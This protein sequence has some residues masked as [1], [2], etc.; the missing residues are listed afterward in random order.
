MHSQSDTVGDHYREAPRQQSRDEPFFEIEHQV[1][2][3]I[4]RG[5]NALVE[6][7]RGCA[8]LSHPIRGRCVG[9][10]GAGSGTG[11]RDVRLDIGPGDRHGMTLSIGAAVHD[12]SSGPHE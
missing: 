2:A 4:Q 9:K 8:L 6:Q 12:S 1:E 7:A 10:Q 11:P 3:G 5:M